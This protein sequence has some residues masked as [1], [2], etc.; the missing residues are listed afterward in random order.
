MGDGADVV[1]PVDTSPPSI[2][3]VL[4]ACLLFLAPDAAVKLY[5]SW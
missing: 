5:G 2:K 1:I 4:I 3:L